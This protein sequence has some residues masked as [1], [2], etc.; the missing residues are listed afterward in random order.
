[1]RPNPSLKFAPSGRWDAPSARPLAALG[2]MEVV[3]TQ[4]STL[5]I[6]GSKMKAI[7]VLLIGIAFV[8]VG[9]FL[10]MKGQPWGWAG[11]IRDGALFLSK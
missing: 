5:V 9:V 7:Q 3:M 11:D 8:V 2:L 6:E 4:E 1:V 10:I